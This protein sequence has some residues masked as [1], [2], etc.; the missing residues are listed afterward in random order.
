MEWNI[1][2]DGRCSARFRQ[3]LQG[4]G[5]VM[6]AVRAVPDCTVNS[7]RRRIPE[8]YKQVGGSLASCQALLTENHEPAV[9]EGVDDRAAGEPA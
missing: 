8:H 2:R 3:V 9:R 4:Q 5:E 1:H 7:P 6:V